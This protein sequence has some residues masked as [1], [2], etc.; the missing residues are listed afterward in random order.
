MNFVL[1]GAPLSGKGTIGDLLSE[2]YQI[3]HISMGDLLRNSAKGDNKYSRYIA[4]H[5][6]SG[7][8]INDDLV[9][10][11]LEDRLN[12]PDCK[13]GY[14]LDGYPRNLEQAIKLDGITTVDKAI[15]TNVSSVTIKNRLNTRFVC[16]VCYTSYNKEIYSKDYCEKCNKKLIKREDDTIETLLD[17][18][19]TFKANVYPILKKY[20]E[21]NKL[22]KIYNEG[23]I[24][25]VFSELVGKIEK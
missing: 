9:K 13:N 16:P 1:I 20:M 14:V 15:Y 2:R 19:K 5:I 23:E 11:V 25:K 7:K 6:E 24:S 12:K 18:I 8:L 4:E 17:R 22:V 3:P 21:E 10:V